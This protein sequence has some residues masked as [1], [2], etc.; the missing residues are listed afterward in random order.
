MNKIITLFLTLCFLVI[1]L[2]WVIILREWYMF[3][4]HQKLINN[5]NSWSFESIWEQENFSENTP[6]YF[7]NL[8]NTAYELF[9][10]EENNREQLEK[11]LEYFKKS[12]ALWLNPDT[13]FNHDIVEKMLEESSPKDAREDEEQEIEK[14]EDASDENQDTEGNNEPESQSEQDSPSNLQINQRDSQ[15]QLGEWQ[16]IWELTPQE[17]RQLEQKIEDLKQEQQYN[18]NSFNKQPQQGSFNS[19]FENFFE[20]SVNRGE[21]K[22]W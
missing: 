17:Q 14:P 1:A 10:F 6:A 7:H 8:W 20:N 5:F 2:I 18:Q 22:D 11:S 13:Q 12:L 4:V 21:E 15:Y 3:Y 16:D 9:D 19:L